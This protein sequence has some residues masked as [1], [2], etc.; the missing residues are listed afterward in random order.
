MTDRGMDFQGS[1][2]GGLLIV[3]F[4]LRSGI[5]RRDDT[6]AYNYDNWVPFPFLTPTLCKVPR[7]LVNVLGI[8]HALY[9][10]LFF[11]RPIVCGPFRMDSNAG[12]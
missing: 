5:Y 10:C 11:T 1:V 7:C 4:I 8:C 9:P 6:L 12:Y 2:F 3:A